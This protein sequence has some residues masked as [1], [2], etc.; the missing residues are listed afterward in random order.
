MIYRSSIDKG[1]CFSMYTYRAVPG[2]SRDNHNE[3]MQHYDLKGFMTVTSFLIL[4]LSFRPP[5]ISWPSLLH[6]FLTHHEE[7]RCYALSWKSVRSLSAVHQINKRYNVRSDWY[8]QAL[9]PTKNLRG[10]SIRRN[11]HNIKSARECYKASFFCYTYLQRE[12]EM[13]HSPRGGH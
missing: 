2:R 9:N 13:W 12:T 7:L 8:S 11:K 5:F 1:R 10:T 4:G 6:T 3:N